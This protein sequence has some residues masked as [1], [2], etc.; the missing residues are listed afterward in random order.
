[1]TISQPGV[2]ETVIA[3]ANVFYSHHHRNV[4][5]TLAVERLFVLRW[6]DRIER[7]WLD[8]LLRN[9]P[10]LG[11]D[12]LQQTRRLMNEALPEARIGVSDDLERLLVKTDA[13]DRHVAAAAI[14]CA[15]AVLVTW[16]IDDFD[17]DE[18][19]SHGVTLSDPDA[20]LCRIFDREPED[21]SAASERAHSFVRRHD[22][23]PT[24][25][26][27]IDAGTWRFRGALA[28]TE[29]YGRASCRYR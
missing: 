24:W 5:V 22:G 28:Y 8:A 11:A 26:E 13:K 9:R 7:E 21:V 2:L 14:K 18:L 29:A 16:N 6:T 4:Y 19:A 17:A 12:R 25:P 15:P 10:D 20:F 3:D 27:Y 1:L 23:H